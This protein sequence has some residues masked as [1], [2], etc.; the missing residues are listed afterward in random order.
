MQFA[1][2]VAVEGRSGGESS[3]G[4]IQKDFNEGFNRKEMFAVG[5]GSACSL[6]LS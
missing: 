3:V 2:V 1:V 5:D 4:V 6:S